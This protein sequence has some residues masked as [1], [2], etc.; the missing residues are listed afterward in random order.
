MHNWK[1]GKCSLCRVKRFRK[2]FTEEELQQMP[3]GVNFEL[4]TGR[5]MVYQIPDGRLFLYAP[6]CI[7]P[8]KEFPPSSEM[9]VQA[10]ANAD[11]AIGGILSNRAAAHW[12]EITALV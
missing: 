8:N 5:F 10:D 1:R 4:P 9:Q 2:R 11:F 12:V 7:G 6:V 3:E